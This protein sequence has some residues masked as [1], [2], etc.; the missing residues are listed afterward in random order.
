MSVD[1]CVHVRECVKINKQMESLT[2][3]KSDA[4]NEEKKGKVIE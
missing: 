2:S 3:S 1:G 4:Y